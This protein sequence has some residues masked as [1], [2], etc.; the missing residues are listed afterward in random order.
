MSRSLWQAVFPY[1]NWAIDWS[2]RKSKGLECILLLSLKSCYLLIVHFFLWKKQS[3][4]YR[5]CKPRKQAL[6][7]SIM[8]HYIM[9]TMCIHRNLSVKKIKWNIFIVQMYINIGYLIHCLHLFK[10][11][12]NSK[13]NGFLAGVRDFK[14]IS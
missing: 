1:L 7:K 6:I 14:E 10:K 3:L 4:E 13:Y 12:L 11:F 8:L 9:W 5:D 2:L